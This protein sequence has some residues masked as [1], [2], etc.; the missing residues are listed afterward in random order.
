MINLSKYFSHN[1]SRKT[2]YLAETKF[3]EKCVNFRCFWRENLK[4][5]F[6]FNPRSDVRIR[7]KGHFSEK[8]NI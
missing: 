3:M 4:K 2:T 1:H 5:Y 8:R 6:R 7:S